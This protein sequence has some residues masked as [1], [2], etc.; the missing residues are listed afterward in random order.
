MNGYLSRLVSSSQAPGINVRPVPAIFSAGTTDNAANASL[1]E[2]ESEITRQQVHAQAPQLGQP[3]PQTI[4]SAA[5]LS[6]VPTHPDIVQTIAQSEESRKSPIPQAPIT[7][8]SA[9]SIH[10]SSSNRQDNHAGHAEQKI[11]ETP[12]VPVVTQI[13]AAP[14]SAV[15]IT[16]KD[17]Q[18]KEPRPRSQSPAPRALLSLTRPVPVDRVDSVY[19]GER[20]HVHPTNLGTPKT[21]RN[22]RSHAQPR[23][24]PPGDE[25]QIHIGRIEVVAVRQTPATAP[26]PPVRSS[27]RLDEYLSRSRGSSR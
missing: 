4:S 17:V 3:E 21:E 16:P 15:E 6:H 20:A 12:R 2:E 22:E 14:K 24:N 19:A 13:V 9:V 11:V 18:V 25:I 8:L 23:P 10:G 1:V 5:D 7:P 26:G 27:P